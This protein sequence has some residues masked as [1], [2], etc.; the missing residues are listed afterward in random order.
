[1]FTNKEY[2]VPETVTSGEKI[3]DLLDSMEIR[4]P[5][6]YYDLSWKE[7][8]YFLEHIRS[9][10]EEGV[11]QLLSDLKHDK[12]LKMLFRVTRDEGG[13]WQNLPNET[14]A[15]KLG[16]FSERSVISFPFQD[17]SFRKAE[18]LDSL[19]ILLSRAL[20]FLRAGALD[21]VPSYDERIAAHHAA[22]T[23]KY[24]LVS[25]NF[26]LEDLERQFEESTYRKAAA[27]L[28][29]P[30]FR[31]IPSEKVVSLRRKEQELYY[32]LEFALAELLCEGEDLR[33]EQT[34]LEKLAEIDDHVRKL[35]SK[36]REIEKA[37]KE[38]KIQML[39]AFAAVGL[40]TLVPVDLATKM[41]AVLGTSNI[42]A[43]AFWRL[44]IGEKNSIASLKEDQFYLL[45]RL[46]HPELKC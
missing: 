2:A 41:A 31:D 4:S 24:R 19:L 15:K 43:F 23:K 30:Y 16:F 8:K 45:W 37:Y 29:L 3:A 32:G 11:D 14:F 39:I 28:Y 40:V 36:Y 6:D 9:N 33:N 46:R 5:Q 13:K 34:L 18:D 12:A 10:S 21:I 42:S 27:T 25:A 17:I 26:Q 22:L 44:K 20:P 35:E 1:V 7:R 38:E